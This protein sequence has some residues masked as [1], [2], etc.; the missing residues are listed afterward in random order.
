MARFRFG[1]GLGFF[2][3]A[4]CVMP[5]WSS[6]LMVGGDVIVGWSA[7]VDEAESDS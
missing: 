2:H 7:L 5:S 6:P 4:F 1:L 3:V